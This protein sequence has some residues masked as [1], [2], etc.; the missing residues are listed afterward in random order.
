MIVFRNY[1]A[2]HFNAPA[3]ER[4]NTP[5][6]PKALGETLKKASQLWIISDSVKNKGPNFIVGVAAVLIMPKKVL[7]NLDSKIFLSLFC[8]SHKSL[9]MIKILMIGK[10]LFKFIPY[11][12]LK[13]HEM[14]INLHLNPNIVL[15]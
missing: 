4:I 12:V 5:P 11:P 2:S 10:G 14:I 15:F 3:L 7:K 9:L 1:S 8:L 13:K 6:T